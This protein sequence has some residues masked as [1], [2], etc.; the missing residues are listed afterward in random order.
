MN[1][2]KLLITSAA[3]AAMVGALGFAVAQTGTGN[4]TG[5]N[6]QTQNQGATPDQPSSTQPYNSGTINRDGTTTGTMNRDGT[7]GT[8]NR[9]GTTSG[10]MNRDGTTGTMNR[11]GTNANNM[12]DMNSGTTGMNRRNR[13]NAD[14]SMSTERA[15]RADRN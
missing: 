2:S 4:T 7:T 11:D 9:D 3:A 12:N 6:P 5:T 8:M 14:G 15:A 13:T 1:A 10:T